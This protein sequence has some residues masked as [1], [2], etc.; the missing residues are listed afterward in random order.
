AGGNGSRFAHDKRYGIDRR[1][2]RAGRSTLLWLGTLAHGT[3][4]PLRHATGAPSE[5]F[6]HD[7]PAESHHQRHKDNAQNQ[8]PVGPDGINKLQDL[9]EIQPDRSEEHTSELQSRLDIVC[10]LLLDI[11]N[12]DR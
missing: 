9:V 10:R 8:P 2:L 1:W 3:G 5:V 11:Y 6:T 4:H 7:T 12:L